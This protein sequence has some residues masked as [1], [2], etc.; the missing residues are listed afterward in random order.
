MWTKEQEFAI[1]KKNSN[2]LVSASAGSGKTAVLVER[3]ISTVI[4]EKIDID[5]LLVVTFTN[6][7]ATELK[8]RLIKAIYNE[9]EKRPEDKFLKNQLT[10]INRANITTI[11]SFCLNLIRANFYNLDIDPNFRICDDIEAKLLKNK[12]MDK[13]IEDKYLQYNELRKKSDD[14]VLLSDILELFSQK[15]EL[16]IEELFKIY[17]YISSFSYPFEYLKDSIEKYNIQDENTD[18]YELSFG[19]KIHDEA[20]G[21]IKILKKRAEKLLEQIRDNEDFKKYFDVL[22]KDIDALDEIL[23]TCSSSWDFLHSKL[24]NINFE[25]N[26][27]YS[28]DNVELK[29]S[30]MYFRNK[31]LKD[32]IKKIKL[33]I[34]AT[35][36]DIIKDNKIAYKYMKYIYNVLEEFDIEFKKLKKNKNVLDFS[37]IEHVALKLLVNKEDGKVTKTEIAKNI[38]DSFYEVYTDEYQDTSYVQE[39]ILQAV[40]S[41]N[42]RFMVGDIKQSIYKFR[43][44]VPD[45]FNK[46][47]LEYESLNNLEQDT[48]NCKIILDKNFRSKKIVLDSINFIFEKIMS[49]Q[50][51]DCNYTSEETLKAGN[52]DFVDYENQNYKTEVNIVDLANCEELKA[53][54]NEEKE[55]DT[56]VDEFLED[57]KGFEIE[58][59]LIALKVKEIVNNFKIYNLKEKSFRKASYK[60][61]VILLR[62]IKEKGSILEKA[63]KDNNIP[64]FSDASTNLLDSDEVRL[65]VAFLKVLDNPLQDIY[66]ASIM[67]SIVGKFSLDDLV[68][69]RKNNKKVNLYFNILDKK[70]E[71]E[72]KKLKNDEQ[73]LLDKI[74]YFLNL[75]DKFNEYKKIYNISELITRI[76]KETSLYYQFSLEKNSMSKKANLDMLIDIALKFEK[77]E[78]K[79]LSAYIEYIDNMKKKID[80]SMGEAKLIGENED[81]VRIMTI[82]KSKGLEF[83]VVILADTNKKYNT[84][85]KS[86]KIVMHD[87]LGIG[88][89]IVDKE[90]GIS[91]P[92]TIKKAI[93]NAIDDETKS[94]ELRMLYVALTRAKEKLIIYSTVKDYQKF[95]KKELVFYEKDKIDPFIISKNN[96]YFQ[97]ISMALKN[98]DSSDLFDVNVLNPKKILMDNTKK[99]YEYNYKDYFNEDL[100][101]DT[102]SKDTLEKF[103][104]DLDY[105]YKY[106]EDTKTER[107]ISVSSLKH[108]EYEKLVEDD[109]KENINQKSNE[110]IESKYSLDDLEEKNIT[111]TRKGTLIHYIVE[112]LDFTLKSKDEIKSY[113]DK[114]V[115]KGIISEFEQKYIDIEKIFKFLNSSLAEEIRNSDYVRQEEEFIFIDKTISNSQIQG[116]IDLYYINSKGNIILVDFKTDRLEDE[117]EFIE[118]YKVQLNVYKKALEKITGKEVEKSI[119]YSFYL[120]KQIVV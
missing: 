8:E 112:N 87:T 58:A 1:N 103:E 92:S 111:A 14:E 41:E 70:K 107:R 63:F 19:K 37:D 81:T 34:Y 61:I 119:I 109:L 6:A 94:E 54:D 97:N 56:E 46:K 3:V 42:N 85:D 65:A 39:A 36:K 48:K 17:N 62:S 47:Y 30:L 77:S 60:D 16:F 73:I 90:R 104:N 86:A 116:I 45:I 110:Y 83:P 33:N 91:Y 13:I 120:N 74:N 113:I 115:V 35:S 26:P 29:E 59:N 52:L 51:G 69:I 95:L 64:A 15:E 93:S 43:Q 68:S 75:L 4:K 99:S 27:R 22:Q 50:N 89:N 108:K 114:L 21:N 98:V 78:N 20:I 31:V 82:H 11:H 44:A 25:N 80:D 53:D 57:K 2:I 72:S 71:L 76:Y 102:L 38:V 9:L 10:Y 105:K 7:S 5:K 117:K 24:N 66:L 96:S 100:L 49:M 23:N 106:L 88:I 118:R 12:A 32:T 67:Y 79:T 40:A 28:G 18:L 55:V 101:S 84:L